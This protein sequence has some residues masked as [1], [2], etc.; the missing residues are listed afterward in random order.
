MYF[1]INFQSCFFY[2]YNFIF[3]CARKKSNNNQTVNQV[4]D[5]L[6]PLFKQ[7]KEH[8]V[9]VQR[10]SSCPFK[11]WLWSHSNFYEAINVHMN[12]WVQHVRLL[13]SVALWRWRSILS[14]FARRSSSA[15][16]NPNS[17]S[18][19]WWAGC[20]S[21]ARFSLWQLFYNTSTWFMAAYIHQTFK[22]RL[23]SYKNLLQKK[24]LPPQRIS[25][26]QK[27]KMQLE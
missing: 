18:I 24:I 21:H 4:L 3:H 23:R 27:H 19:G 12:V 15:L 22:T 26:P 9:Q 16:W 2:K 11:R 17:D 14:F 20:G 1:L 6:R 13:M 25:F 5:V 7:V 10:R 8:Q